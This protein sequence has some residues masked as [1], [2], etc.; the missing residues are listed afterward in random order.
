LPQCMLIYT[1]ENGVLFFILREKWLC[2][3]MN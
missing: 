2:M 1:L 3:S